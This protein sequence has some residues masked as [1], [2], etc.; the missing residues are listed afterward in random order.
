MS[1]P[2]RLSNRSLTAAGAV[3]FLATFGLY[4]ISSPASLYLDDSGETV[5]VAVLLGIGHPPGYPL[6]TLLAHFFTL[7]PWASPSWRVNLLGCLAGAATV[8]LLAAA[9]LRPWRWRLE[10]PLA[11]ASALAGAGFLAVGPVFWHNALGAKG[12]IYQLNNLLSVALLALLLGPEAPTRRA[13][14]AFWLVGGL[15]LAHHYMSQSVLLPAYAWL[16]WR[17]RGGLRWSDAWLTLPGVALYAYLP[18]RWAQDPGL[19]WGDFGDWGAFWFYFL[20]LQY[21]AGELTRS[22]STSVTQA[23]HALSLLWREGSGLLSLLA[24]SALLTRR[25]DPRIQALGLGLLGPWLAVTVYLN[26]KPERLDLM[27]P[28]LFPA[29]L[30]QAWLAVESLAWILERG[31]AVLARLL[32]LSAAVAL[33]LT[34]SLRL[35]VLSLASYYYAV[36]NARSLLTS[37]PRNALLLAQGDA[38]I[39]PLWYLQRVL[40]ERRDVAV[41]GMAVLPME[42]V[43]RDLGR[44]HP[45]LKHPLVRGPIGAESVAALTDAY[46]KLNGHRPLYAAFNRF[47]PPLAGWALVGEACAWRV[48]RAPAPAADLT[49]TL[50]RLQAAQVRGFTRRPLDERTLQLIVGDRAVAY[51]SVGV[52]AEAQAEA[53]LAARQDPGP[54]YQI[55]LEAYQRAA[56]IHPED[57]DYPFNQGNVYHALRRPDLAIQSWQA[58]LRLDAR[59]SGAW[60]NLGVVHYQLGEREAARTAFR[61]VLEL[62]PSR[63]DVR[64]ILNGLGG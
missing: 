5:S 32:P 27:K 43:R 19:A 50:R 17:R 54:A 41:V 20:R 63:N 58:A 9:A 10:D 46:L 60:Y 35:P 57:P 53:L 47:D 62:D 37:L 33:T 24:L 55:A 1:S 64:Q 34:L 56:R 16:L 29:Y 49:G 45:D 8:V 52:A 12:S 28:Y 42:W 30:C 22:L 48:F 61:R 11:I 40:H 44:Q 3:L 21:A 13:G 2:R 6:H 7:L 39:F 38:L 23:W 4:L 26:L 36:D 25:K 18:L 51:N 31:G 15:A 59:Y 14:R